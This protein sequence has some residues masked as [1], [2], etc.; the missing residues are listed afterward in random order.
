M[1]QKTRYN[2]RLAE[3]KNIKI[4]IS[5]EIKPVIMV[6]TLFPTLNFQP[7]LIN[8]LSWVKRSLFGV[9]DH[10]FMLLPIASRSVDSLWLIISPTFN[11]TLIF[12]TS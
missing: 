1:K 2:I 7:L 4:F 9:T 10:L 12:M 11:S 3:K 5:K 6:A 8:T